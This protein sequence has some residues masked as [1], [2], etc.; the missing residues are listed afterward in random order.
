MDIDGNTIKRTEAG[1]L[2]VD[3]SV[4]GGG[5]GDND[6]GFN[7]EAAFESLDS[8]VARNAGR[9]AAVEQYLLT[10]KHPEEGVTPTIEVVNYPD[11]EDLTAQNGTLKF[12]DRQPSAYRGRG[13][14][15]LRKNIIE[16]VNVLS[17]DMFALPNTTYIV[18]YDYDARGQAISIPTG[19]ELRFEG[20]SIS[21]S[22]LIG[23]GTTISAGQY[24]IFG[25]NVVISGEWCCADVYDAWLP[26]SGGG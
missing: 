23:N 12:A 19:C 15:Y 4:F 7:A 17:T 1:T 14:V 11:N 21:N 26:L 20:G 10:M 24:R 2:Y 22:T 3:K 18:Q 5:E 8:G 6:S 25:D 13:R 9:I 16:D